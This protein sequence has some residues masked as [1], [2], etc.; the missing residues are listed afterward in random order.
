MIIPVIFFLIFVALSWIVFSPLFRNNFEY[1]IVIDENQGAIDTYK[2]NLYNQIQEVEFEKEMG[3]T[4]DE[5]Y[6]F[7][8]QGLLT[9]VGNI[10][11]NPD[12]LSQK[13]KSGI[14]QECRSSINKNDKFCSNCGYNIFSCSKCGS[15]ITQTDKFCSNCGDLLK[16]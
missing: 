11:E 10:L 1:E 8:K 12:G 6:Q 9:E 5:D 14:C 16:N 15:I 2:K 7:V 4:T 3:T 13:K